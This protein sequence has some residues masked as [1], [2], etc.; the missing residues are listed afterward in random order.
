ML[1]QYEHYIIRQSEPIASHQSVQS[2]AEDRLLKLGA[3]FQNNFHDEGI[4]TK[5]CHG[6][7]L[8][9]KY[10]I[11][12][13][14]F[15]DL[16]IIDSATFADYLLQKDKFKNLRGL[17]EEIQCPLLVIPSNFTDFHELII[18]KESEEKVVKAVKSIKSTLT[19]SLR[20]AEVSLLSELPMKEEEFQDEKRLMDFLKQYFRNVGI[21]LTPDK[22]LEEFTL[23]FIEN[24]QMPLLVLSGFDKRR[25]NELILPLITNSR[26]KEISLYIENPF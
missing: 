8:N 7:Y 3:S 11:K 9:T 13:T 23:E 19:Q 5:V 20:N 15:A 26:Q 17:L 22:S 10:I 25:I 18:L 12:E 21:M 4:S 1:N 6:E 24:A 14:A 16:L 2:E